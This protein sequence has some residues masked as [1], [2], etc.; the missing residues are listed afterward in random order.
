MVFI[1]NLLAGVLMFDYVVWKRKYRRQA[2]AIFA[3]ESKEENVCRHS[4][5]EGCASLLAT[6]CAVSESLQIHVGG[7]VP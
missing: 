1:L 2:F 6:V 4:H 3:S 7:Y 5:I